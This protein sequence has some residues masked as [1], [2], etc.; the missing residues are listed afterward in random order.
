MPCRVGSPLAKASITPPSAGQRQAM[1]LVAGMTTAAGFGAI[2][3]VGFDTDGVEGRRATPPCPPGYRRRRWPGWMVYG[4]GMSFQIARSSAVMPFSV[5]I[6]YT[7][8]PRCTTAMAPYFGCETRTGRSPAGGRAELRACAPGVRITWLRPQ[9]ASSARTTQAMS[10]RC[11]RMRI[12]MPHVPA[13]PANR[14]APPAPPARPSRS[15]R[16]TDAAHVRRARRR[17]GSPPP[18]GTGACRA[19]PA[20]S[21]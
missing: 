20:C 9:A 8:W 13:T 19:R 18:P 14:P 16:C 21:A 10:K 17:S 6:R 12:I 3:P 2:A 15:A 7:V 5:A 4:G 1:L 11:V